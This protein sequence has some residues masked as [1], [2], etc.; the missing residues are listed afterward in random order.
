MIK[1]RLLSTALLFNDNDELLMM[2]R[3]ANRTLSPGKWAAVGGHIEPHE[4]ATPRDTCQREVWEETG[5]GA[6]QIR[7][8]QLRY[9]LL[10][11]YGNELR[12]Q[13]FYTGRTNANPSI[14][15]NEGKL[16]WIPK[17]DVLNPD[18]DMP[19]V[20][21][22]LLTHYFAHEDCPHPWIGTAGMPND[23]LVPTI[24][25]NPLIDPKIV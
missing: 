1:L 11:L 17:Y 7:D 8:L 25:W 22:S 15:T 10:R 20:F 2:K 18:R 6:E 21:R 13:F 12:Q 3:S 24:H 14:E 9:V 16:F 4:I 19:Y 23:E 5:I